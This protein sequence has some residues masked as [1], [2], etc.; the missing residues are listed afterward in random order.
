M[1]LFVPMFREYLYRCN[2]YFYYCDRFIALV[3]AKYNTEKKNWFTNSSLLATDTL[4]SVRNVIFVTCIAYG[5]PNVFLALIEFRMFCF[6]R[7][8]QP[9]RTIRLNR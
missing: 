4:P 3:Y 9:G 7:N 8:T 2:V 6:V 5:D 1:I